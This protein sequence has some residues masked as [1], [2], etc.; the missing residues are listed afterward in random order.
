MLA[1]APG[2]VRTSI[3]LAML[4]VPATSLA[5]QAR[6]A[7]APDNAGFTLPEGFCAVLVAEGLPAPRHLVVRSDGDVFVA[8][9]GGRGGGGGVYALRDADG[10]GRAERVERFGDVGGNGIFLDGERLWFAPND[11][12][13]RFHVPAGSLRPSSGPET[14]VSGLP[15]QASHRAKSIALDGRGNLFV[16]IG[17]PSN[18]CQPREAER[19]T[20]G[21]DPCPELERRAGIWRFDASRTG[22]TQADGERFA[23]GVRNA[24]ALAW[25]PATGALYAAVHGRDALFQSFPGL[26][27][28]VVGAEKP[29]EELFRVERGDDVGWPDC[30]YDPIE[31]RKELA[32]E[33]GGDDARAG[34]CAAAKDPLYGFPGHWAPNGLLFYTGGMF[35]A[36]YRGGAFVAFHGSWNRSPRP[37]AGY[38]VTFLPL[39]GDRPTG[40]HE[41]FM[42]GFLGSGDGPQNAEK[43]PVGLAQG[44]DGSLYVTDDRGGTVWRI[45]YRGG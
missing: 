18:V 44:P 43:R 16:N 24:V 25:R 45:V 30:Y 13:L 20:S 15:D 36:R 22:Q 9:A 41:V 31:R 5:A 3:F 34:R 8:A 6:P 1:P 38:N 42:G 29:A 7:C 23:T 14:V 37:Q 33:Y 17:S 11:R 21:P 39:D 4:A 40:T 19:T 26:Y 12:V 2:A 32:P 10:D 35:P 28:E 27:D